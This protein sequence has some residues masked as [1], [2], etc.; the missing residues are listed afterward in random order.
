MKVKAIT[1]NGRFISA[2][3]IHLDFFMYEHIPDR[4]YDSE[5]TIE[6]LI[7]FR[8]LVNRDGSQNQ[9]IENLKKCEMS[10]CK[11]IIK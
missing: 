2:D 1:H 9:I 11:L 6:S 5:T 10:I 3:N 4:L 7:E 8:Q